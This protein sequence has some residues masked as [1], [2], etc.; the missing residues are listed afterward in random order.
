MECKL[1]AQFVV[2]VL[3]DLSLSTIVIILNILDYC[4]I[5]ACTSILNYTDIVKHSTRSTD[6][7]YR[8][9]KTSSILIGLI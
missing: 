2:I 4:K 9:L 5:V 8:H 3:I 1:I 7:N 6:L